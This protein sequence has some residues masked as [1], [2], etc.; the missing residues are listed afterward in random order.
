LARVA[1]GDTVAT[2]SK[3]DQEQVN[4]ATIPTI[5]QDPTLQAID[6][7]MVLRSFE[8]ARPYLG[9]SSIGQ[10]C[11]RRLWYSFRWYTK[12]HFPGRILRL[13]NRGHLEEGRIIALLLAAGIEV[14]QQDENGKQFRISGSH[15]HYGG[16]GDG[17][18]RGLPDLPPGT[19]VVL[20]FKTHNDKSFASIVKDGVRAS[21]L[22]HWVQTQQ[23]MRKMSI[24]VTLY[25]AVNKNDDSLY[26]ELIPI[27]T[28]AADQYIERAD[29]LI[30][31]KEE[32]ARIG[33]P[34]SP[35]NF[36]CKWCDH[37]PVCWLKAEPDRNCRTCAKSEPMQTGDAVWRCNLHNLDIPKEVQLIGCDRYVK[38]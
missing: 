25:V 20:E 7:A 28:A 24:A 19:P 11:S 14:W 22:V 26:M 18:A 4:M 29:K 3:P 1:T 33:N 37:K 35:G 17:I 5:E 2:Q 30:W 36:E 27:D 10:P 34:P 13:F 16:S 38:R 8:D 6:A 23:Y 32:P 31:M 21:K 15:G 9:A 12:P